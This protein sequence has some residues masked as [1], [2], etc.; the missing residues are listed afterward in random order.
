MVLMYF[1]VFFLSFHAF[2]FFVAYTYIRYLYALTSLVSFL[3]QTLLHV[4]FMIN[5]NQSCFTVNSRKVYNLMLKLDIK[6]II[7][8][9]IMCSHKYAL[10]ANTN[11][12]RFKDYSCMGDCI[13]LIVVANSTKFFLYRVNLTCQM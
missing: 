10:Y 8:F 3:N 6:C 5:D 4:A 12:F 7:I 13:Q 9:Q 2:Y 1:T 11:T